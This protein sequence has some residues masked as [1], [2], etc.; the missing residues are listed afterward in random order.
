MNIFEKICMV[1]TIPVGGVFMVGGGIGLF[2]GC[3]VQITFPPILGV[4]LFFLGFAMCVFLVRYWKLGNERA[5][6]KRDA[7]QLAKNRWE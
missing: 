5:Q 6:F 3:D 1:L 2:T 7:R 4:L